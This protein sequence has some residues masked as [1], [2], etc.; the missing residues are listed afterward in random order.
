[1][2]VWALLPLL[3]VPVGYAWPFFNG[4]AIDHRLTYR[5]PHYWQAALADAD[6]KTPRGER[7]M[8]L[9][10]QL[11]SWYRWGETVASI[12]PALTERPVLVRQVTRYA[13]PRAS[14]LQD[15]VDDLVQQSR[16][17][18]GQLKPLLRLMAVGRVLVPADGVGDQT[19]EPDPATAARA[20]AGDLPPTTP[21]ARYG[22]RALYSP[23]PERG[24]AA[25]ELPDIRAY[26]VPA[27]GQ[28][29]RPSPP[30][31]RGDPGRRRVR[32]GGAGCD[33]RPR[34]VARAVLC[35]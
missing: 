5:V 2:P 10:G 3:A 12:A 9:P 1:M 16:L 33:R 27:E 28:W 23:D 13:D 14:N 11:F 17:V 20:L 8:V 24:G 32:G 6:R 21:T 19:G 35:G 4:T 30:R 34:H 26:S 22:A 15:V 18:P 31:R 25:L 7:I 29:N